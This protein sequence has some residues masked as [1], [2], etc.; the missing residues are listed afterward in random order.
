M[1]SSR[2]GRRTIVVDGVRYSW[3][4]RGTDE[5]GIAVSV[6]TDDAF[7]SGQRGQWLHFHVPY[8][9]LMSAH[10]AS[11][12]AHQR[13]RVTPGLVRRAIEFACRRKPPFTGRGGEP[14]VQLS[15]EDVAALVAEAPLERIQGELRRVE[16]QLARLTAEMFE[17]DGDATLVCTAEVL[18]AYWLEIARIEEMVHDDAVRDTV[19]TW[20]K[21]HA[22]ARLQVTA[23]I[24]MATNAISS[25]LAKSWPAWQGAHSRCCERRSG[26]AFFLERCARAGLSEVVARIDTSEVDA[27]FRAW[28]EPFDRDMSFGWIPGSHFWW[29]P[30]RRRPA[31]I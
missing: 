10:E 14:D 28:N 8:D 9:S 3:Q 25:T 21:A 12:G 4:A 27:R 19:N 22:D 18:L 23:P 24:Q 5:G 15:R 6:A 2:K 1:S 11:W 13:A 17:K 26:L 16:V 30:P 31:R 7:V 20:L 29:S